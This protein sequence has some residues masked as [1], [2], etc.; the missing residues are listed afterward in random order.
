MKATL[1]F[2]AECNNLLYPK[3]DQGRGKI[4]YACRICAYD[5]LTEN[6]CVYRNDLL[7][8][9]KCV[10]IPHRVF[11]CS[12][13]SSLSGNKLALQQ[14][15]ARTLL[16][17]DSFLRSLAWSLVSDL[18]FIVAFEHSMSAL[19]SRRVRQ[20]SLCPSQFPLFSYSAVFFQDQSKRKE[21]RMILFY[22]CTKCNHNFTDP[23]LVSE[24][25]PEVDA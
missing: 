1:H 10:L 8:V 24:I 12:F 7:T 6:S 20:V 2:C 23:E 19:W 16:W 22:V 3:A 15:L 18:R 17:Y 9:T 21:T 11:W 5:E 13:S 4:Y 25:R 14:T